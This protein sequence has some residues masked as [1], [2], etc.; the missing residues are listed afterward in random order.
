M[1]MID[2][3][4]FFA[5]EEQCAEWDAQLLAEYPILANEPGESW[6]TAPGWYW[7]SDNDDDDGPFETYEECAADAERAQRLVEIGGPIAI[8]EVIGQ[9][10]GLIPPSSPTKH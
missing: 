5:D 8:A 9:Q 10:M 6:R 4:L 3:V 2:Y 1:K 7:R